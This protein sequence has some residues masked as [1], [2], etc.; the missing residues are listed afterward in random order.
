[1]DTE[2]S[3]GLGELSQ[4]YYVQN[5]EIVKVLGLPDYTFME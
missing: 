2:A 4:S 3:E 1:M 5:K